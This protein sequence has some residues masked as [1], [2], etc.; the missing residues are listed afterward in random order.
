MSSFKYL[1]HLIEPL[2]KII[3]SSIKQ[4]CEIGIPPKVWK[5]IYCLEANRLLIFLD[6]SSAARI[7]KEGDKGSPYLSPQEDGKIL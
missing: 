7:N 6:K 2:Q 3:K 1:I 4:R 5:Y